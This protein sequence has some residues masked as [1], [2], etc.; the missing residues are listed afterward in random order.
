MSRGRLIY[1]FVG[2]F[3]IMDVVATA[4]DP[5]DTGPHTSGYDPDFR[6][7]VKVEDPEN[8]DRNYGIAAKESN[9][10]RVPFQEDDVDRWEFLRMLGSGNSPSNTMRI[11]LHIDD[12]E[13]LGLL[14]SNTGGLIIKPDDQLVAVYDR[15]EVLIQTVRDP[16][17][18]YVREVS[19]NFGFRSGRNLFFLTL[20]SRDL[21]PMTGGMGGLGG[22]A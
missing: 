19:P 13:E 11:V 16:P 21:G 14:D 17:G 8:P 18:L 6:E 7:I 12:I 2:E 1:P 3:K 4:A 20:E 5:D 15:D 9:I 10:I 22:M